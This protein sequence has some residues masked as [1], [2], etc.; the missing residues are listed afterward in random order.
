MPDIEWVKLYID[1]FNNRKVL[2][3]R[4]L[5]KGNDIVLIWIM[6]LTIAGRCNADGLIY[7]TEKIPYTIKG[8]AEELKFKP[9]DIEKA[10]NV[11]EQYDMIS[12]SGNMIS[13]PGWEEYQNTDGMERVRSQGRIRQEKYRAR[14]REK[15][16]SIQ[17]NVTVT[18]HNGDV[19]QQNKKEELE[20]EEKKECKKE[21]ENQIVELILIDGSQ[22][23]IHKADV[24][25]WSKLYPGVNVEQQFRNMAGWCIGNPTKRKTK[26]GIRR[27]IN[28]WLAKSQ[29]ESEDNGRTGR[30]ADPNERDSYGEFFDESFQ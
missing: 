23:P 7:V 11:L 27:F 6:L 20:Q 17:S 13:I 19:T 18:L 24:A 2:Q 21:S 29:K 15:A 14:Q 5:P 28:T 8:L 12:K 25:E 3:I 30:N 4:L 1:A 10:L 26:S 16:E 22:Y 9:K